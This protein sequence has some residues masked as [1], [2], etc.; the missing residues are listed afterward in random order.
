MHFPFLQ[1]NCALDPFTLHK[2]LQMYQ[3]CLPRMEP[4]HGSM[5]K[6]SERY[7]MNGSTLQNT[8]STERM[9]G[10]LGYSFYFSF[11]LQCFS[12]LQLPE[13]QAPT[14]HIPFVSCHSD[15]TTQHSNILPCGLE[16]QNGLGWRGPTRSSHSNPPCPWAGTHL[17]YIYHKHSLY[18]SSSFC[19]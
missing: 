10:S 14:W 7:W 16:S 19:F 8:T 6:I 17:S 1:E 13:S 3:C 9:W 18:F 12:S 11:L 4:Q 5:V 15:K 2:W